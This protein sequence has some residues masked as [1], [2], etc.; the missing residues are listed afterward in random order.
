MI[1]YNYSI[2]QK[3]GKRLV[4]C[5]S[6]FGMQTQV[7]Y[8]LNY[9][10]KANKIETII[11]S[12]AQPNMISGVIE[13]NLH[14]TEIMGS[15]SKFYGGTEKND[16]NSLVSPTLSLSAIDFSNV[17]IV[18][19]VNPS[20]SESFT[21]TGSN[22]TADATIV[23]NTTD[24]ELSTDN[25][26]FFP[27][28][29]LARSGNNLTGQP[30][31]IYV[32]L[33]SGLTLGNKTALL[34]ASSTDATN[35]TI[36]LNGK[37]INEAPA[38][39]RTNMMNFDG[40]T[41]NQAVSVSSNVSN[42]LTKMSVETWVKIGSWRDYGGIISKGTTYGSRWF[43]LQGATAA[44]SAND[45]II[46]IENNNT[47]GQSWAYTN[48]DV[49]PTNQWTHI[50]MVFDGTE[51]T[52]ATKLKC[53]INGMLQSLIFPNLNIPNSIV[54]NPSTLFFGN[55]GIGNLTY[56]S[57]DEIRI[58]N[59]ARTQNQIRENMH[60]TSSG[61]EAD[62]LAYYQFNETS[63]NAVD[64]VAGNNGTLINAPTRTPSEV[65]VATGTS[66]RMNIVTGL[67]TFV[68]SNLAIN[69]TAPTPTDEFV[70]YQLRGNPI[71]SVN[72][73][74]QGT[75]TS[76]C[77]WIVRQFGAGS[78]AYN[79]MNFTLP[80]SNT[81]STTDVAT[82]SN[83]KLYKRPDNSAA[84]FPAFFAQAT[85]ANN[86]TKVIQFTGFTSQTSF[87]QFEIGSTSSPLPMTLLSFEGKRKDNDNVNLTWKTATE[88]NNKGFEIET[89]KNA[90]DFTKIAFSDGFGHSNT[91]KNY[92]LDT[93]NN[94]D[95][96]YRLKQID[97]N[98]SFSYSNVI[99]IKAGETEINIYPIPTTDNLT[100]E[101]NNWK[102]GD[103][104]A[105]ELQDLQGKLL[106]KDI[107]KGNKTT[108]DL[109]HL[110][111]GLYLLHITQNNK[112][113]VRKIVIQ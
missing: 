55:D 81:I 43:I 25:S 112:K 90:I 99:F 106:L 2:Y 83:L 29:N 58:W 35:Q 92:T 13:D 70:A 47:T 78:V 10:H 53:Y 107:F 52:N 98:G 82:P 8:G 71:N 93:K 26:T 95:S 59:T 57:F 101:L 42:G 17:R 113:I 77:Y 110:S 44:G 79:G 3:I 75:N 108:I 1:K 72:A 102:N 94:E 18:T 54:T 33:K 88:I 100:I 97:F 28:L 40:T 37:I 67:N 6:L 11:T 19:N 9:N 76:T 36:T 68:N 23:I 4:L 39:S 105:F 86:S 62:L 46:G 14:L 84:V 65:A 89:S 27:T 31:T 64:A 32:R 15:I 20:T 56:G 96:Y 85:S 60:L 69:F 103:I 74:N 73:L 51:N 50:A 24:W 61:F 5:L 91:I 63:G 12:T 109:A 38:L 104:N 87:S 80:S 48:T 34:T 22:L 41:L 45:I 49:I 7:F 21:I 111:K 16:A 66:S 30:V